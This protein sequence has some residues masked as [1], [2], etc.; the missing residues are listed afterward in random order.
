MGLD[1]AEFIIAIEDEF[2]VEI[3]E[4]EAPNID[5]LDKLIAYLEQETA[6]SPHSKTEAA[7]AFQDGFLSLQRFFAEELGVEISQ[8]TPETELAPLLIPLRKRRRIWKKMIKDFSR[9]IPSLY[10]KVYLECGGRICVFIGFFFGL[11]VT[12][13]LGVNVT[14][15]LT[16]MVSGAIGGFVLF[17]A[18]LFLFSPLFST[19]PKECRTLGGLAK[20]AV[21]AKICLNSNGQVWTR[22]TITEAVLRITSEQTLVPVEKI[23]LTE[24]FDRIFC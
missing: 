12:I 23:S 21:P 6:K 20:I 9:R 17:L 19:I 15:F 11:F 4:N 8:L 24:K 16:G 14:T 13:G 10:G 18:G 1:I 5:T 22:E 7:D 2:Q 3:W